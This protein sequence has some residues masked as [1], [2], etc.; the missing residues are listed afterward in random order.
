MAIVEEIN[1]RKVAPIDISASG[2]ASVQLTFLHLFSP[3]NLKYYFL[4]S[5]NAEITRPTE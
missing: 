1:V 3:A 5:K 4:N 2:E